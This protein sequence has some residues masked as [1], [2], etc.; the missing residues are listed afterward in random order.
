MI[1][2]KKLNYPGGG[3]EGRVGGEAEGRVAGEWVGVESREKGRRKKEDDKSLDNAG[4][5]AS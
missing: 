2:K 4:Y 3:A 1:Q 5:S